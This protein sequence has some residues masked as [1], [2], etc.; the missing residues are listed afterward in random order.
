MDRDQQQ[1][2]AEAVERK[3]REAKEASEAPH[4]ENPHGS[5]VEGGT[6]SSVTDTGRPHDTGDSGAKPA[7]QKGGGASKRWST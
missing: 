4:D 5:K 1:R 6:Q 7:G 3:K 2:F